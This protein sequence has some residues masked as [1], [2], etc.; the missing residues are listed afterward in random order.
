[1]LDGIVDRADVMT[2]LFFAI[3]GFTILRIYPSARNSRISEFKKRFLLRLII[4]SGCIFFSVV[5]FM[6]I[7]LAI[8]D[9]EEGKL[10]IGGLI[11][12]VC[13]F[14]CVPLVLYMLLISVFAKFSFFDSQIKFIYRID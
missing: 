8:K 10:V 11:L 2:S 3:L 13:V 6:G 7:G 14:F 9:I 4:I 1:M 12:T 5:I